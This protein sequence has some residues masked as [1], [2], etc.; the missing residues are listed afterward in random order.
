VPTAGTASTAGRVAIERLR[1]AAYSPGA[2]PF[3]LMA[4]G[5]F[6]LGLVSELRSGLNGDS[7]WLLHVAGRVVAGAQ[8][9]ADVI[10]VNPPLVV[11]FSLITVAVARLLHVSEIVTYQVF[12]W[13]LVGLSLWLFDRMLTGLRDPEDSRYRRGLLLGA[14][15]I[16]LALPGPY[17]G[18]REHLTLALVLPWIVTT[19]ARAGGR[20][21][22]TADAVAAGLL[23]GL[24]IALK[25]HYVLLALGL[26][27]LSWYRSP[28]RRLRLPPEHAA[29]AAVLGSYVLLSLILAPAYLAMMTR[30]GTVYWKYGLRSLGTMLSGTIP[31]LTA[32]GV[33]AL[34]PAARRLTR[35]P[36]LADALGVSTAALL[37]A[38]LIQH[39]GFGYHF[40]PAIGAGLLLLLAGLLGGS[41]RPLLLPLRLGLA[42]LCLMV[43][44]PYS[45][46]YLETALGRAGGNRQRSPV[47]AGSRE[48]AAFV[49]GHEPHGSIVV[50]SPWMEDSFPWVL[51]TGTEWG[52]RYPFMWFVPAL[53]RK[54][55]KSG[56]PLRYRS[57]QEMGPVARRL[58]HSVA[59][60]LQRF[61]PA[62]VFVRRPVGPGFLR[63][64]ILAA[65]Q[66]GPEFR[67]AF[68]PYRPVMELEHFRV[69]QR[70]PANPQEP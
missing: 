43:A 21:P 53:Y 54:A 57:E 16:L 10:E 29:V 6:L 51:E 24:G 30:L 2:L 12:V 19:A 47:T 13:G 56:E 5:F 59:D 37:G 55:L 20:V 65:F 9:Y 63:L 52:S 69:F 22:D 62:Y 27:V 11:W 42:G 45:V 61:R 50:Y 60:D 39:K 41:A 31:P 23:A 36:T 15:A 38:V 26:G 33:L 58:I 44:L 64:D 46:L 35:Y 28:D 18:Q 8:L 49:R 25:P 70:L 48:L 40:Y 66:E 68:A 7:A 4:A 32:I 17:F 1:S 14:A 67:R 3:W 34:W